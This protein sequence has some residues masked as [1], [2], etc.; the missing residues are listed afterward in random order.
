M[1]KKMKRYKF[2]FKELVKRDFKQKY[3]KTVLGMFWSVLHPILDF[4]VMRFVF[5]YLFER[6]IDHYTTYLFSGILVNSYF[7][8]STNGGMLSLTSNAGILQK[9]NVPK[10]MFLLSKNV[11][12]FIN[13][14]LTMSVY[15]IFAGLD[16][17]GP[18]WRFILL[19]YPTLC[20]IVFN[21][22]MGLILSALYVFF[23]DT[24]YLY[25]VFC[26]LL[27]YVS[28]L[29]YEVESFPEKMQ[30]FFLLNPIYDYITYFR[31]IVIARQIPDLRLHLLCA[32]YALVALV[33]GAIVYKRNNYKFVFYF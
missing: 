13:Y 5:S 22:G 33:V 15:F 2:L 16:G 11:S 20:L 26:K 19:L 7:N 12:V 14:L 1:I 18:T 17:I 6:N 24:Q 4:L 30:P 32:G 9:I 29:F 10:Y 21:I 8:E 28:A 31:T 27:M 23:K 25:S 3:K